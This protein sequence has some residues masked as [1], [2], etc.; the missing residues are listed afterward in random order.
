ME[1]RP[2]P[3]IPGAYAREDGR[4]KLPETTAMMPSGV[5]R[6]Y[7]TKWKLGTVTKASRTAR[8]KYLGML[9]RG[10]NY[11]IHR[12]V[13]TAFHGEAPEGKSVVIH[14]NENAL[15]NRP[16]NLRWG[17]QK[18]NLNAPGFIE[19]CKGR[20]GEDNPYVKGRKFR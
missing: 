17:T 10:R 6:I 8:H 16:S 1:T 9:Y 5:M 11:K 13:C 3:Q 15:D 12:L 4:I 18:E 14:L 20:T 7:K 2:I 19:Y